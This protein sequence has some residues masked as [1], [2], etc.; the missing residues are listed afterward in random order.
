MTTLPIIE[1]PNDILTSPTKKIREVTTELTGLIDQMV[2]T[3]R[4]VDGLGLA[5][6]Q[7][8]HTIRLTVIE[9][10]PDKGENKRAAIPLLV[11]INPKIISRSSEEEIGEEGCLS[12]PGI[13]LDVARSLRIKVRAETTTGEQ[14]QFRATGL[15]ARIIQHEVDHLDGKLIIDYAP[16]RDALIKQYLATRDK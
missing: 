11:L 2:A 8:G 1:Y 9:Y 16:R 10:R 5:A 7:V 4:A 15:L 6:P 3:M 12:L 14:I 13:E